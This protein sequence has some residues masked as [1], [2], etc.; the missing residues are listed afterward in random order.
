MK[1]AIY[2]WFVKIH[3]NGN[4]TNILIIIKE[5]YNL[6]VDNYFSKIILD[7]SKDIVTFNG[8]VQK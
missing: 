5:K 7:D 4:I 3:F 1:I 8:N 6:V 2:S